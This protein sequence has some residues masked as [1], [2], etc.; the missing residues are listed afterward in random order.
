MATW[1]AIPSKRA[2]A[3]VAAV[4]AAWQQRGY[5]VAL[6]RDTGD[7]PVACDMLLTGQYPGY[8]RAVNALCAEILQ[9]DAECQWIVTGGDD[10]QPDPTRMADEISIECSAHFGGT[11]GVMQPTGDRWGERP[12]LG[13]THP[14]HSAYIDRIC[15]SP[16]MGREWCERA[17]GGRGPLWPDFYHMF[18]D[19]FLQ[20]SAKRQNALWQRRDLTH[21]H[22][23]WMRES[24]HGPCPDFL[25]KVNGPNHWSEAQA[26]YNRLAGRRFSD[27]D[28]IPC[29]TYDTPNGMAVCWRGDF[30]P[31]NHVPDPAIDW[32]SVRAGRAPE[33]DFARCS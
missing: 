27:G 3:E 18:V 29:R 20:E 19:Q 17:N 2:A 9:R 14:M 10:I 1:Y 28:A 26:L 7:D 5:R 22:Q 24:G 4:V 32:G 25:A 6:W 11:F 13:C 16:F 15:G 31:P 8:A 33:F 23:H 21:L 30:S 12:E